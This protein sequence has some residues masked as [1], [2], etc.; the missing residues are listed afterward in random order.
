M[1]LTLDQ[2]KAA[3]TEDFVNQLTDD[4]DGSGEATEDVTEA[5]TTAEKLARSDVDSHLRNRYDVPLSD[6]PDEIMNIMIPLVWF[7][8][9]Q[10]RGGKIPEDV[11]T[12]RDDAIRALEKLA[13]GKTSLPVD[14]GGSSVVPSM[15]I[16]TRRR[17]FSDSLMNR[18]K[19]SS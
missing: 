11:R 2:L 4:V 15:S 18:Y 12:D 3:K 10:G 9:H 16:K 14:K 19:G 7:Y 6:V 5:F 17:V 1:Y 8:L 13:V